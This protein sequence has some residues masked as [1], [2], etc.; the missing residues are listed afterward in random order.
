M[1]IGEEL[2]QREIGNGNGNGIGE[3]AL[4]LYERN[5]LARRS[6]LRC[7]ADA[8]SQKIGRIS[9]VCRE[10]RGRWIVIAIERCTD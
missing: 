4:R 1:G 2:Y 7:Q 8:R 3:E 10:S 9:F 6:A 5:Y